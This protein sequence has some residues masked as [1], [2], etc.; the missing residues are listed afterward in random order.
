[1][2]WTTPTTFVSGNVLTAAQMNTDVRDN[3]NFL[4]SPPMAVVQRSTNQVIATGTVTYISFNTEVKDTDGIWAIGVPTR[5]EPNTAGLYLIVASGFFASNATG[6]RDLTV[7]VDGIADITGIRVKADTTGNAWV[8]TS[9]VRA[10]NGT[11][12]YIEMGVLQNSGGNLD[13]WQAQMSVHFI[14]P[15]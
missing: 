7:R 13:F 11:T 9:H 6:V 2:P 3:T 15:S 14:G 1:M 12:N 4:Y 8:A 10:F 5:I